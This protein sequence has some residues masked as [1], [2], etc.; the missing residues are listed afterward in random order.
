MIDLVDAFGYEETSFDQPGFEKYFKAYMKKVLTYLK[1]KKS[2]R[3][4]SFMKGGRAFF[5]WIKANFA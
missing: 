1:E 3:V 4:D 2:D 5:D